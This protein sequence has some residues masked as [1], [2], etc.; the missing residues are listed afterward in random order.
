MPPGGSTIFHFEIY[1][2]L[3]SV[4]PAMNYSKQSVI[5]NRIIN[6]NT[7]PLQP[8]PPYLC[9]SQNVDHFCVILRSDN[10]LRPLII[11]HCVSRIQMFCTFYH[12][13]STFDPKSNS[14]GSTDF[15]LC[16]CFTPC[17]LNYK[18]CFSFLLGTS[19]SQGNKNNNQR[20]KSVW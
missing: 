3:T 4:H 10:I 1:L 6:Q 8:T 18:H 17:K 16:F 19:K 14:N 13:P 9:T 12:I 20:M 15:I 7:I 2:G 11:S 5:Q